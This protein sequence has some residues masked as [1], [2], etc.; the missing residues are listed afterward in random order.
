MSHLGFQ[1]LSMDVCNLGFAG[2]LESG[3]SNLNNKTPFSLNEH[4]LQ[5]SKSGTIF[6][7]TK[8]TTSNLFQEIKS[9]NKPPNKKKHGMFFETNLVFQV[10]LFISPAS[11]VFLSPAT[12]RC[13]SPRHVAWGLRTSPWRAG[14]G[15]R[16]FLQ[17]KRERIFLVFF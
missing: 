10:W 7:S 8:M 6:S 17:Q 4:K 13:V 16:P 3:F 12:A 1:R 9:Q 15:N 5:P 11:L 14:A 2:F